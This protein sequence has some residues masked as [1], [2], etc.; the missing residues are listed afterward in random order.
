MD[1]DLW[2]NTYAAEKEG[3]YWVEGVQNWV[4]GVQSYFDTNLEASPLDGVHN[5][6]NTRTELKV[7]DRSPHDLVQ[8]V[9]GDMPRP[10]ICP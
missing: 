6:V 1:A 7:Y 5:H 3:Q 8:S 9:F 2:H 10:R 4:E